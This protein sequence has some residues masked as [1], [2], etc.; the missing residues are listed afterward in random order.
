MRLKHFD[1]TTLVEELYKKKLKNN[2]LSPLLAQSTPGNIR[3]ECANV[4]KERYE[5]KDEQTLRAFFGP[6]ETGKKFL[7]LIQDFDV[8]RFRPLDNYLKS[9]GKR[10][11][12]HTNLELLAWLINFEYRPYSS[13]NDII[14]SREQAELI[15][16]AN[17]E[18]EKRITVEADDFSEEEAIHSEYILQDKIDTITSEDE[19]QA[20]GIVIPK[21]INLKHNVG[22]SVIIFLLLIIIGGGLYTRWQNEKLKNSNCMYW[23]SD[24]YEEVFCNEERNGRLFLPKD[25]NMINSFKRIT[26]KDTITAL[27]IG[28]IYYISNSNKSDSDKIEYY[29]AAGE[30]P[31]DLTRNV[32]KLT[33]R[34]F[35]KDSLNRKIVK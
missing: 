3:R 30:Y 33:R 4:Y 10:T 16:V 9:G 24:H 31:E 17:A 34:I 19:E 20:S 7:I 22:K 21:Q 27:H 13:D 25:E 5:K 15:A 8:N 18:T 26:R 11:I 2:K 28:K 35:D 23:D 14:L 29:T 32:R 1:Y 12:N 6:A